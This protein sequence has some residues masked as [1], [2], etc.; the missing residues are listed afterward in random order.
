MPKLSTAE[1]TV[2]RELVSAVSDLLAAVIRAGVAEAGAPSATAKAR[3]SDVII[4]VAE[5]D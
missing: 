4:G 3:L 5:S 2:I 1:K